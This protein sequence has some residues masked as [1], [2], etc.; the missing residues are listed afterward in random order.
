M[1]QPQLFSCAGGSHAVS[2]EPNAAA[3]I[4]ASPWLANCQLA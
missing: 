3:V 1:R 2:S 4:A